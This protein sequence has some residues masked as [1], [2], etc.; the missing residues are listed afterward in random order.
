MTWSIGEAGKELGKARP[1]RS[2]MRR[3]RKTCAP[4]GKEALEGK[5]KPTGDEWPGRKNM[6]LKRVPSGRLVLARLRGQR[7]KFSPGPSQAPTP[8]SLLCREANRSASARFACRQT[9]SAK[10]DT[11]G[12]CGSSAAWRIG[13]SF[14]AL[15]PLFPGGLVRTP[16]FSSC[17]AVRLQKIP[18]ENSMSPGC[19]PSLFF[20]IACKQEADS[21]CIC[22]RPLACASPPN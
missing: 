2:G 5:K 6:A 7:H 9:A 14:S 8:P 12:L 1:H 19:G 16:G 17:H 4:R 18:P 11:R 15:E 20:L 10:T 21:D 3:S 13:A 22:E